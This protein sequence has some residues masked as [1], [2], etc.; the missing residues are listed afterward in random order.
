L[1][2]GTPLCIPDRENLRLGVV[3][4]IELNKKPMNQA[5]VKDGSVAIK[6]TNDGS[7][8]YGR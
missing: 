1:R 5:R 8:C 4:S 3:A 2:V 6:I 7:V